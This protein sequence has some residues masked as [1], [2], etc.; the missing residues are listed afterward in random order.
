VPG[1]VFD[2]SSALVGRPPVKGLHSTIALAYD[3]RAELPNEHSDLRDAPLEFKLSNSTESQLPLG[4]T[5]WRSRYPGCGSRH[6]T[7]C[8]G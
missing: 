6:K 1:S 5:L 8:G 2:V 3:T 4:L 7:E